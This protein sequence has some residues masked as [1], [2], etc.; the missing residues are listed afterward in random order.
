MT[1]SNQEI[2]LEFGRQRW[3]AGSGDCS[4]VLVDHGG[5]CGESAVVH[6]QQA[7]RKLDLRHGVCQLSHPTQLRPSYGC[8]DP[9]GCTPRSMTPADGPAAPSNQPGSAEPSW[10]QPEEV[11][12]WSAYAA[13]GSEFQSLCTDEGL[14]RRIGEAFSGRPHRRVAGCGDTEQEQKC[15]DGVWCGKPERFSSDVDHCGD[16]EVEDLDGRTAMS[17]STDLFGVRS[18]GTVLCHC[19]R[20]CTRCRCIKHSQSK[21]WTPG[22]GKRLNQP[23][24]S[25]LLPV[26]TTV[27]GTWSSSRST[28]FT[29]STALKEPAC[30]GFA[31][32]C[33]SDPGPVP[34]PLRHTDLDQT[35]C[36][37]S[38]P[39]GQRRR[40][41]TLPTPIQHTLLVPYYFSSAGLSTLSTFDLERTGA[42]VGEEEPAAVITSRSG[43][44]R[45]QISSLSESGLS[46]S[47]VQTTSLWS[48]ASSQ[49]AESSD[50]A[51]AEVRL[52]H[53][54][55]DKVMMY[56]PAESS[57]S[58]EA[59]MWLAR[60][61]AEKQYSGEVLELE[62]C[63][64]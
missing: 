64:R 50:S 15:S 43:R 19:D 9:C 33:D 62:Q 3:A 40:D 41:V 22:A 51:E 7:S 17:L 38:S 53:Q 14:G 10:E 37:R 23:L 56:Q 13:A 4:G 63:Q 30:S 28:P 60:Q 45:S 46:R 18:T 6:R 47:S 39:T 34:E 29:Q 49:P 27:S 44:S 2:G 25:M 54:R 52:A 57:D 11:P 31:S 36:V 59:R 48:A 5:A 8:R 42:G 26:H 16:I 61:R 55:A 58:A 24:G 32:S 12:G 1:E 35:G 21:D 20:D